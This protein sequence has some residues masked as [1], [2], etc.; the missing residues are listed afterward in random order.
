MGHALITA[1]TSGLGRQVIQSFL[2]AGHRVTTTYHRNP[3]RAREVREELAS[4]SHLLH[5]EQADVTKKEDL[6]K[7]INRAVEYHGGID[8]LINNAGPFV[9]ERKKLLDYSE[10]EWDEM[11]NGNLDAVFYLLKLTVPYMRRQRFGRIVNYGFQGANNASGW[12]YRS[13]FAAA[14]SGLASLTKTIAFEE[15]ENQITSNMVCPGNITGKMKEAGIVDS[16]RVE[17]DK[18]PIGRP[19]TGEDIAR[20]ILFLCDED[21]DM[22][23]GSVFEITGGVDVINRYR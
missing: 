21:S 7:L 3:E 4:Y 5:I 6:N 16:R 14:K 23:T 10:D 17:N 1:G 13:A 20:M 12:M 15:A 18:T 2:E 8:Y 19:G 9:F 22:I 11:I